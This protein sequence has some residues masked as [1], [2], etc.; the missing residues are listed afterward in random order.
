MPQ[1]EFKNTETGEITEV[2]LRISEY[3]EWKENNPQWER[4]HS[5]NSAPKLVSGTK[6]AMTI[7]GK[8]WESHLKNIKK[9]AGK[10]NTVNV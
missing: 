7:A 2:T 3:D 6:S 10:D 8:D 5:S 4:Y 9:S 1:Y